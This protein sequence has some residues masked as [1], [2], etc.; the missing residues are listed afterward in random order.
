[1][2]TSR[3]ILI[4]ILILVAAGG[5]YAYQ[6]Y[7]RRPADLTE[8]KADFNLGAAELITAFSNDEGAA[9]KSYLNKNLA[10]KGVIRSID[11]DDKGLNSVL[12]GTDVDISSVSCQMDSVHNADAGRLKVGEEVTMKGVCT[13]YL[14]DVILVRCVIEK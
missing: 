14:T 12:L 4:V 8:L 7:N 1:M 10:V 6:E 5:W 9:N 11:K 13:G 2:K 3:Y